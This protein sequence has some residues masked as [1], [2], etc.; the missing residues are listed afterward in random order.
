LCSSLTCSAPGPPWK[1]LL[2]LLLLRWLRAPEK[3]R[4]GAAICTRPGLA[5]APPLAGLAAPPGCPLAAPSPPSLASLWTFLEGF[6]EGRWGEWEEK[7]RGA[8][9]E[10][11]GSCIGGWPCFQVERGAPAC[12][13]GSHWVTLGHTGSHWVTWGGGRASRWR[14]EHQPARQGHTRV[15]L[16]HKCYYQV[17][18]LDE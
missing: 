15:T 16:G 13:T 14:E 9:P 4:V 17:R 5:A 6:L 8:P 2:C 3:C 18:D 1:I 12:K 10:R 11:R 7:R